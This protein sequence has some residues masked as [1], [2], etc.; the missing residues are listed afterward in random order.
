MTTMIFVGGNNEKNGEFTKEDERKLAR[1]L[2]RYINGFTVLPHIGAWK[3]GQEQ[4]R[5]IIVEGVKQKTLRP[6]VKELKDKL[7]QEAIGVL[8]IPNQI[9]FM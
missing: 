6:M 4:G 8:E 5:T 2:L 9:T 3:G 7:K 1:V